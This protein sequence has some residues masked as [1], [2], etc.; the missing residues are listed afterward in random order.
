MLAARV[1]EMEHRLFPQ[2][3]SWLAAGRIT[4]TPVGG[5]L[6]DG[7]DHPELRTLLHPLLMGART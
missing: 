2:V 7:E 6:L 5:V 3:L 4:L 1:L